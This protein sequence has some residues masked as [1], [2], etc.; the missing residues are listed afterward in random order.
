[1]LTG[2]I[3]LGGTKI[4]CA[5][6]SED[7]TIMD[8]IRIPTTTPA[9]FTSSAL[10]YFSGYCIGSLGVAS[11]GPISLNRS[12]SAYGHI[13]DTPKRPWSGFDVISALRP[14]TKRIAID[15]DV[16]CAALGEYL[17]GRHS[18]CS[19]LVYA[20][21]GTGIGAGVVIDGKPLHGSLH[22]EIGHLVIRIHDGDQFRGC[23]P[24]HGDCLEGM[25]SGSAICERCDVP[26]EDVADDDPV[27]ELESSYLAQLVVDCIRSF[28][29]E[30]IILGKGVMT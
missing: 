23:C 8:R 25:A 14:L 11:F 3:E 16:N 27:W 7:G 19:P 6:L 26:A 20:T 13:L 30:R 15:T 24:F 28:S 17:Y 12:S 2:A 29:P 22:P 5:V 1:M 9:E 4:I 18:G 10:D 21:I